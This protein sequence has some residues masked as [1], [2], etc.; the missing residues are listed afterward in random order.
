[1]FKI[2]DRVSVTVTG[3][4]KGTY[5][6]VVAA[7]ETLPYGA[8]SSIVERP[9]GRLGLVLDNNPFGVGVAYFWESDLTLVESA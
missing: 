8:I 9:S 1:M 7:I 2:G 3:L 5:V 6:G 4:H